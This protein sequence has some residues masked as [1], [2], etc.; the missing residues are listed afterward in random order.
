MEIVVR[1]TVIFFFLWVLT[2]GLGKRA[3]SQLSAFEL[4]LLVT[5]GDLVQAGVTQEDVSVTGAMLAASTMAFW[6]LAFS[7][8]DWRWK[9]A[10]HVIDGIPAI[11]VSDGKLVE[12]AVRIERLPIDDLI[13][14]ARK[15]GIGSL[16]EV[17]LGVLEP[18]GTISFV[19]ESGGDG[20]RGGRQRPYPKASP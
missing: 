2:R 12:E 11:V 1:A 18:D 20:Q 5:I 7:V 13:E 6:V 3:L 14:A 10:R 15:Q 9:R 4:V 19:K 17:R 16:E 8:V